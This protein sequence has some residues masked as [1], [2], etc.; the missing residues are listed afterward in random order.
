MGPLMRIPENGGTPVA[1]TSAPAWQPTIL[2]DRRHFLFLGGEEDMVA[3]EAIYAGS[4]DSNEIR[5]ITQANSKAEFSPSGHL[6]FMRGTTLMAQPF[7]ASGL[8]T[9]GDAFPIDSDV[10]ITAVSRAASF[11][12]SS[13][14]LI[15][16]RQGSINRY[17]LTWFD[18]SGKSSGVVDDTSTYQDIE[19]SP[20]GKAVAATRLNPKTLLTGLWV[21]DLVRGTSGSLQD[22]GELPGKLFLRN[23]L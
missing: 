8:R 23:A 16:Y 14:G 3:D 12:V 19:L 11:S 22:S 18:R 20:D 6:L 21:I 13:N 2:P 1:V 7:D 10:S 17:A 9:T 5:K 15:V 4:L